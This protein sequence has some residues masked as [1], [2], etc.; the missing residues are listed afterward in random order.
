MRSCNKIREDKYQ[1]VE[2]KRDVR[3]WKYRELIID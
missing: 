2:R 1:R 3:K